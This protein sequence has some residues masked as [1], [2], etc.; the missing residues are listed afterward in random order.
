MKQKILNALRTKFQRF[1]LS[2]E[3][4]DRIASALEKTVTAESDI[5]TAIAGAGT[6]ELIANELQKS[7]DA[8]RRVR[9]DLQKSF[10]EYKGKHPEETKPDPQKPSGGNDEVLTLLRKMQEDNEALKR[11][12]DERDSAVRTGEMKQKVLSAL[13]DAKR[14]NPAVI[15]GIMRGFVVGKDDTVDGLIRRYTDAYDADYK[16]YYGNGVIP[17]VGNMFPAREQHGKGDFKGAVDRLRSSGVLP[18][19]KQQ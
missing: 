15:D 5:E 13:R 3:A 1:G 10:D 8:E 14:E 4:V 17:P 16:K 2:N 7:A 6:M 11:R 9:S 19:K 12:L 18:D